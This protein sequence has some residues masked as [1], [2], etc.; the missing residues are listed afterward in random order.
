MHIYLNI[1]LGKTFVN[2]EKIEKIW[3]NHKQMTESPLVRIATGTLT[4]FVLLDFL[5]KVKVQIHYFYRYN[6]TVPDEVI[7]LK[8]LDTTPFI[9]KNIFCCFYHSTLIVKEYCLGTTVYLY[10]LI[11][12]IVHF[13]CF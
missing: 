4:L 8:L 2:K 11:F 9:N 1:S 3:K 10:C 13:F 7:L 12:Q 6:Q 5:T